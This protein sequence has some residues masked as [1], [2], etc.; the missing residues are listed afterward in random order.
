MFSML[1]LS[2]TNKKGMRVPE[3]QKLFQYVRREQKCEIWKRENKRK[4]Q[5]TEGKNPELKK[6]DEKNW[7]K[8]LN[9]K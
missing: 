6:S 9:Y 4:I 5:K 1:Q 7:I 8:N 2:S 3:K